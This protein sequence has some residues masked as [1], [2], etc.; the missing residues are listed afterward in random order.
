MLSM[1]NELLGKPSTP[2]MATITG[3][4]HDSREVVDGDL[5]V[6]LKGAEHDGHQYIIDAITRGAVAI[7]VSAG[8]AFMDSSYPVSVWSV[9]DTR[10]ILGVLA[11]VVYGDPTDRLFLTGVTGTNGKTSTTRMMAHVANEMGL[12]TGTIGTLGAFYKEWTLPTERTTPEAS[13]LQHMFASMLAAGAEGL[14]FEVASHALSQGRVNNCLFD[15]VVFTNLTQD[16]LDYHGDMQSYFQTKSTLFHDHVDRAIRAGKH[17]FAIINTASHWGRD[18]ASS[19]IS[20]PVITYALVDSGDVDVFS[21]NVC[22]SPGGS[23]FRCCYKGVKVD[24]R[25]PIGGGFQVEN[26][27]ACIA[28]GVAQGWDIQRVCQTLE[29]CPQVPGRFESVSSLAPFDVIVDYAHSPD[30]LHAVL[31]SIRGLSKGRVICVFGCGGDRDKTKRP[32]MGMIA[33]DLADVVIITSDN[34]R[35]EDPDAIITDILAGVDDSGQLFVETDRRAAIQL[36]LSVA[37]PGDVVLLAGKGHEDYQIIGE[38]KHPFDDR[39][40]AREILVS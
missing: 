10:E 7:V 23:V 5:Y 32:L 17:P 4:K 8:H 25:L 26:A 18:L 14:V 24:V 11:A 9:S 29:T 30:G 6:C 19:V 1:L 40:V 39:L 2:L 28:W 12:A 36:A 27:L 34:P 15:A 16:H 21:E 13:T 33:S 3:V 20:I 31:T 35:T 22:L 38:H 37:L